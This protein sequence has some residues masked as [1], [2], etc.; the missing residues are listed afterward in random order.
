MFDRRLTALLV[1]F[2]LALT[3]IVARLVTLQIVWGDFYQQSA[4]RSYLVT[5][6]AIPFVRGS[7]LDRTG[8]VLV[9]DQPCWDLTMDYDVIAAVADDQAGAIMPAIKRWR[10]RYP[11]AAAQQDL[12]RC[13]REELETM[14]GDI[15]LAFTTPQGAVSIGELR[16]RADEINRRVQRIREVVAARRGFDSPVAEE[17]A[18]HPIWRRLDSRLQIAAREKFARYP[19]LHVESSSA[20]RFTDDTEAFA[21]VL[22]Q[23]G[24]V[25]AETVAADPDSDDPFAHYR[26]DESRG[27]SGVEHA[28]EATLRG[29]RGQVTY[30]RDGSVVEDIEAEHGQDVTLTLHSGLQRRLYRLLGDTVSGIPESSGGAIVVLDVPRREVL[31]LVSYPAFA[32]NAFDEMYSEYRD[33]TEHLPLLFRAVAGRYAPGSTVK[34]LACLA[35]LMNGKLTLDTREECTGYLFPDQ[36]DRWRCWEIHGTDERKAHGLV[37]VTEALTGSC[38]IFMYRLG[39]RLGVDRLLSVFDMAG[40]GR[41]CG[42]NLREEDVGINPTPEW[43]QTHRHTTVSAA[44]ARLFAIGQGE[45]SMTPL[46]VA[47]LMA[48]YAAGSYRPVTL[49]RGTTPR[50]E[51]KLPVTPAQ[52]RAVREGIYGVVNDPEGTAYKYAHLVDE[53]CVLCGKTGSATAYPWPTAYRIPYVDED[54]VSSVTVVAAGTRNAAMDRFRLDHPRTHADQKS[55]TVA[56]EWPR[57]SP[58]PGEQ[59]AHAWF[60]GFLQAVDADHR[61]DWSKTPDLAFA[62]LVEFG[63]SG[64]RTSGPLAKAVA[65]ELLQLRREIA[66]GN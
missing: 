33:D 51:W 45:L 43:L 37:N 59:H 36:R 28:A 44:H 62:V 26:A 11:Q 16:A 12:E 63:G 66:F 10:Q 64:G 3:V 18:A 17:R 31:A 38:N 32:P 48:T 35:G 65:T 49:V 23:T 13:F 22:G 58:P 46:Q 8:E 39:E 5:P 21:H 56:R 47:N 42:I 27:I 55:A 19:W 41:S 14:W 34:P 57:Q 2:A 50:P 61:P 20:R 1:V 40:I 54:G 6:R 7:I 60:G 52:W 9:S 15:A 24:R 29:R 30:D 4:E 25:D 53:H